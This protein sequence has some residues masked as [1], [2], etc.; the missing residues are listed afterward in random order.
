MEIHVRDDI[1][2][3]EVWLNRAEA[4]DDALRERMAPWYRRW[5]QQ[6]YLVAVFSSGEGDLFELTKFLLQKNL[7]EMAQNSQSTD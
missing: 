6:K 4:K 1:R 5:K 7:M 2:T 3:I